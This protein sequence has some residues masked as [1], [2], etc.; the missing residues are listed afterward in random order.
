MASFST[1]WSLSPLLTWGLFHR[2]LGLILLISFTSLAF[3]VVPAI[4]SKSILPIEL[5]LKKLAHDFPTWRRFFYFPTLLW[6]SQK[7]WV[8]R[9][10]ALT[11]LTSAALVVIGGPHSVA[12]I[13]VCYVCYLSLDLPMALILPWDTLL[14]EMTVLALFLPATHML[15]N[16]D[17]TVAPAPAL[18]WAFR[19]LLFRVVFGFGKQ[20]FIGARRKDLAYLK[21]YLLNQPLPSPGGWYMQKLPVWMLRGG[22]LFMF[23]VEIP[24]PFFV[25]FPGWLSVVCGVTVIFLMVGIQVTG[26]FGYFSLLTM[27]LAIPL[28][29]NVTPQAFH[30]LSLF[31]AG[32]PWVVNAFVVAHT[33]AALM[34]FPFN[35]WLAQG[36]HLWAFWY[37]LPR[38]CQL[39]FTL[40]R[41]L[42]PFRWVHPYGV[43]PPNNGPAVKITVLVEVTWDKKVWHELPFKFAPS[44]PSTPPHVV[45]PHHPRGEQA[46]IYDTFG[47]NGTSLISTAIPGW[48]PSTFCMPLP[49]VVFCQAIVRGGL[50]YA[51]K[52]TE[53]ERRTD[54]PLAARVTT[55][56]LE[57]VSLKDRSE[58]GNWWKRTYIGPHTVAQQY[59]PDF[60]DDVTGEPE[61]WHFDAIF[62]RRRSRLRPL[63]DRAL[64]G[65]EDPL[66]LVRLD[67]PEAGPADVDRFWNELVPLIA[68]P[69]RDSF[70][71]LPDT[72]GEI[73]RRFSRKERRV[74]YRLLARFGW[75]LVARLEPLFH[76]RG[77]K[78]LI[79]VRSNFHLSMLAHHIIGCGRDAYLAAVKN[80]E[81]VSGYAPALT[82]HTGLYSLGVFRFEAMTF[83]AQ[84]L[85]L[86]ETYFYPHDPEKKRA[87]QEKMKLEDISA[88]PK[89]EQLAIRVLRATF[90]FF[91]LVPHLREGFRGPKFER[92]YPELYPTFTEL[93]SGEVVVG[94]YKPLSPDTEL[95]PDLKSLPTLPN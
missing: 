72:I 56:M 45:A 36:W 59:D 51:F 27:V 57:A 42:Q 82:V 33:L 39:P 52:G 44:H 11:G 7:D 64:A 37:Q 68:A 74:Q 73:E 9:G 50:R 70:D 65:K 86:L 46:I 17:A 94:S 53:L 34:T 28:F 81:S 66:E 1:S 14:L 58:T 30:L 24:A 10:I 21:G 84:K 89:N 90:G 26:N 5:R 3:Q 43:F 2:G 87:M 31:D 92:G 29:D 69:S 62:W 67:F 55:V 35:S 71:S 61:L 25:F 85:R 22:V 15:P 54:P 12:A 19:L 41:A 23:F 38:V 4:G 8:L 76:Y 18:T 13:V 48:D 91:S 20:K 49:G 79:V 6:I 78:P 40:L 16:L 75:I 47:M 95:A 93:E 63:L 80:P 88:L 83:D 60:Y 32:Q 77:T